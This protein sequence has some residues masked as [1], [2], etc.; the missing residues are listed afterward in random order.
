[1]KKLP[2]FDITSINELVEYCKQEFSSAIN[3]SSGSSIRDQLN[4]V[5][6][7]T[8]VKPKELENLVEL[9]QEHYEIWSWFMELNE[10]RTSNGFGMNPIS[11][12]DISAYFNLQ[13]ITPHKWEVDTLRRLDR[14][15]LNIYAKKS[16]ADSKKKS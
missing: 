7:Q 9:K 13:E 6:Q 11:Y 14:E 3:G 15:V 1:V 8:G 2:T 16:Q 10:S 4:N 5:W 12:S